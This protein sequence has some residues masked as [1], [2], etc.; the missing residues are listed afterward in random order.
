[1]RTQGGYKTK[2][3]EKILQ[4]LNQN[5]D[6][7][8][9]VDE[10]VELLRLNGESVGKTTV[11]RYID[12]LCTEGLVRKYFLPEGDGACY[13]LCDKNCKQHFHLKCVDCGELIHTECDFLAGVAEHVNAEHGFV[14]DPGLTV[15]YGFCEH[16]NS[17]RTIVPV[18]KN[19]ENCKCCH[20]V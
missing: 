17:K 9:N 14:I 12:K 13:Q 4:C 3:R 20:N 8:L 16:C 2:Q 15:L 1:M 5:P 19:H 6:R 18:P 11:Y 10:I 7:H